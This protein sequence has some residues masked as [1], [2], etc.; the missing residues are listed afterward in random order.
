ME[1]VFSI[2]YPESVLSFLL[3]VILGILFLFQGIDKLFKV[4]IPKVTSTFQAELGRI[5]IP[6]WILF[7]T[8]IFSSFV[9]FAG[10]ILL[11]IGLFK[12]YA[13]YLLG[14]D[15]ILVTIAFSLIQ[16]VWDMKYVWPR[17]ILLAILLYLPA[18]WDALSLDALL[19]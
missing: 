18:Q 15:L 1:N 2:I 19:K 8:A 3:R 16:P 10:G 11:I 12:Y 6:R 4:G 13:M 9:E 5:K 17:L 14:I 7:I